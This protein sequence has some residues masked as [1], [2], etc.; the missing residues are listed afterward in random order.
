MYPPAIIETLSLV[1]PLGLCFHDAATGERVI[2]GLSVSVYPVTPETVRKRRTAALPNRSGVFVLHKAAGLEEFTRGEGSAEFWQ[3]NPPQKSYIVEVF[4]TESRFQSFQFSLKLPVKGIYRWENVPLASPNKNL[5]S[6]PLYSAPARKVLGGMS[7][8]RAELRESKEKAASF[9]VLEARF[10]GTLVARGVADRDGQIVLMFPA[11][12][13]QNNPF[14]SPPSDA[15]R[16]SLAEQKWN[17][18]LTLKYEPAI[19]QISP[20]SENEGEALPDLRLVLA[21]KSGKLWANDGKTES[22][23][24]AVLQVDKELVLRSRRTISPPTETAFSSYLFVSP[25]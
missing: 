8:I 19:F 9:A 13:P 12:S 7:V 1:A 24:T 15:V 11:L 17:L 5:S 22:L 16:V 20:P 6:I 2:D 10:N 3:K 4:D 21:Q 23:T 18:D 25:A 14:T